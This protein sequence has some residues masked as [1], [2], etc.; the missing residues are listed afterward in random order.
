MGRL[1]DDGSSKGEGYAKDTNRIGGSEVFERIELSRE[2]PSTSKRGGG[3]EKAISRQMTTDTTS[4]KNGFDRKQSLGG[5]NNWFREGSQRF[6]KKS[7]RRIT[8]K[9][10]AVVQRGSI[11]GGASLLS[12]ST[13]IQG[14]APGK[15]KKGGCGEIRVDPV[16]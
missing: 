14:E 2:G 16:Q 1:T 6:T 15:K 13:D 10:N 12:K 11:R 5:E 7:E 4:R 3:G 9:G 8:A